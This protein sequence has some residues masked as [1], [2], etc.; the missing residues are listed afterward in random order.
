MLVDIR[1]NMYENGEWVFVCLSKGNGGWVFV[2]LSKGNGGNCS[3][4]KCLFV[5]VEGERGAVGWV[6]VF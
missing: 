5:W 4:Y 1:F 3:R 6:E 2:C